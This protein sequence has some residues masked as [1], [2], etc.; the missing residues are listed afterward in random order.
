MDKIGRRNHE[1]VEF[2]IPQ[3]TH[4]ASRRERKKRKRPAGISSYE[5]GGVRQFADDRRVVAAPLPTV[6]ESGQVKRARK[7]LVLKRKEEKL[8]ANAE[9]VSA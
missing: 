7:Q 5:R 8:M 4:P 9:E 3:E 2:D 6:S 1:P